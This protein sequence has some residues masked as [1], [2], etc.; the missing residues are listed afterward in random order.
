MMKDHNE[1]RTLPNPLKTVQA[2]LTAVLR[3]IEP[4]LD[5]LFKQAV[6][7]GW[8]EL[9]LYESIEEA[10]D[11]IHSLLEIIANLPPFISWSFDF[12]QGA[13]GKWFDAQ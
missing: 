13:D 9:F 4:Q 2:Y 10:T 12:E 7:G 6:D 5:G 1:H 3:S 8:G 11:A